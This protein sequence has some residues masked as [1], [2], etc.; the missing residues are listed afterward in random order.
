MLSNSLAS[1]L[2]VHEGSR[3]TVDDSKA[4]IS[5]VLSRPSVQVCKFCELKTAGLQCLCFGFRD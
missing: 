4:K 1:R 2:R 3:G 5:D